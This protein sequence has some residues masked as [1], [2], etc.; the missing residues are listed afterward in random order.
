MLNR[1]RNSRF[2]LFKDKI[3]VKSKRSQVTIFIILAI[4][5]VV[6]LALIF[7]G[8]DRVKQ[9]FVPSSPID[10]FEKCLQEK[11]KVGLGL[12]SS[13]G[14]SVNPEN[15][16]LYN[17]SK[18]GYLCYTNEYYK[19]CVTQIPLLKQ[20]M[21]SE[22]KN[23]IEPG[24]NECLTELKTVLEKSGSVSYNKPNITVNINQGSVLIEIGLDLLINKE[25]QTSY[26]SIKTSFNSNIYNEVMIA[27]SITNWE[28]KYGDSEVVNFMLFY[29]SL[30]LEKRRQDDGTKI[31]IITE[32]ESNDKFVF[33]ERSNAIPA[34]VT[35]N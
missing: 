3:L 6:V 25:S 20:H 23:Y 28:A 18:V 31:Y 10:Q 7:L 27:S 32:R 21:E 11:T 9:V 4:M 16:Y 5:I 22:L 15:Y 29:P 35:G 17:D 13:Q 2:Y 19:K 8:T 12:I 24:T 33:A 34:G 1:S 26:K 30:K 14:G